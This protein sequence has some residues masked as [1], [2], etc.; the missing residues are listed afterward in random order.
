MIYDDN[1]P[2]LLNWANVILADKDAAKYVSGISF[3]QYFKASDAVL[4]TLYKKHP[5]Y[6]RLNTEACVIHDVIYG[7]WQWA[8]KYAFDIISVSLSKIS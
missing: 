4:D 3:H 1:T 8:E 5:E 7:S 6:F 2:H